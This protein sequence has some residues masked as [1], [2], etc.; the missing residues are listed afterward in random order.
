[1]NLKRSDGSRLFLLCLSSF[2]VFLFSLLISLE[3]HG[4]GWRT[5]TLRVES[6]AW[7]SSI[8]DSF[9]LYKSSLW[10]TST[11][12][13]KTVK[14]FRCYLGM[15]LTDVDRFQVTERD[16]FPLIARPSNNIWTARWVAWV[17]WVAC[18]LK[19]NASSRLIKLIVETSE[20]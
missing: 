6:D 4:A 19:L 17:A 12:Q 3:Y 5:V 11:S 16:G 7:Q 8:L 20:V 9:E 18:S 1:M 15:Q 13:Q 10:R 2:L 14:I